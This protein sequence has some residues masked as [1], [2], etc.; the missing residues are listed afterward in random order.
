MVGA[1]EPEHFGLQDPRDDLSALERGDLAGV[2]T[3]VLLIRLAP[4]TPNW[5]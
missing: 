5:W 3:D 4:R 2:E 1:S